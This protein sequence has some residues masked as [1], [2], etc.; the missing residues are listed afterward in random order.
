MK[1]RLVVACPLAVL[2]LTVCGPALACHC[3]R[4]FA[5]KRIEFKQ[6]TVT[7]F[8]WAN[9]HSLVAFDVKDANDNVVRWV[10]EM[11]WARVLRLH[12]WSKTS[13]EAGDV[14]TIR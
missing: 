9:P 6:V 10:V 1:G 12:G 14:V 13:I 4:G 3:N 2:V 7:K 5:D 11:G 8:V